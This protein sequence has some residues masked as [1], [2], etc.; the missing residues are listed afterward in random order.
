MKNNAKEII[1]NQNK[2]NTVVSIILSVKLKKI[3]GKSSN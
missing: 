3:R 2:T 1:A